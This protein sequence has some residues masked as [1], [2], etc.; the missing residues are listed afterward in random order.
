VDVTEL[1]GDETGQ[2]Q[3]SRYTAAQEIGRAMMAYDG[4][5]SVIGGAEADRAPDV[6]HL[7]LGLSRVNRAYQAA[8]YE[9]ATGSTGSFHVTIYQGETSLV[10]AVKD[11]GSNKIPLHSSTDVLAEQGRGLALV[12]LMA[13]RWGH[14]GNSHGRTVWFELRWNPLLP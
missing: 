6:T 7:V 1:T 5:E 8:R 2:P 13:S 11:D 12:D 4:L 10:I 14:C 3:V 9:E